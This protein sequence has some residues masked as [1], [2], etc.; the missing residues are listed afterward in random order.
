MPAGRPRKF[1]DVELMQEK[2]DQYFLDC[3]ERKVKYTVP[4]LAWALGF[5]SRMS[6]WEYGK[7][8][9]F[10]DTIKGAMLKIEIQRAEDLVTEV[11][12]PTGKIFDLKNNFGWK[13]EKYLGIDAEIGVK[14]L[15]D[16]QLMLRIAA[17]ESKLSTMIPEKI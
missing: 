15:T 14:N 11:T 16:D 12:N 2:I 9:E 17:L 3:D 4:G 10:T 7:H 1:T 5:V 8:P 6:V 13:D